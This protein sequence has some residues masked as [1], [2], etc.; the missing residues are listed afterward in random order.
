MNAALYPWLFLLSAL[1]P[2]LAAYPAPPPAPQ[3]AYWSDH[4][5]FTDSCPY[6]CN[7]GYYRNGTACSLFPT[8]TTTTTAAATTRIT[9][10][11]ATPTPATPAISAQQAGTTTLPPPIGTTT[12]AP[13]AGTT[14]PA[15]QAGTTTLPP[16]IGTTPTPGVYL[17]FQISYDLVTAPSA[18]EITAL[19][20]KIAISLSISS[21][22][23]SIKV[24]PAARRRLLSG[25]FVLTVTITLDSE[26]DARDVAAQTATPA[27][28]ASL[29]TDSAVLV[30]YVANSAAVQVVGQAPAATTA[31][32]APAPA[33]SGGGGVTQ[34]QPAT[35]TASAAA[36][37][38]PQSSIGIIVAA[39]AV[40][41]VVIAAVATG[42]ALYLRKPAQATQAANE[43]PVIPIR[44]D[45]TPT[46]ATGFVQNP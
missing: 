40:P 26:E 44:I 42:V 31:S 41:V 17:T 24:S 10:A 39:V 3:N 20:M 13:Q 12:L 7:P 18:D 28:Q 36:A 34:D 30:T 38:S 1:H 16:L 37:D 15:P 32:Q 25:G 9:T 21:A 8:T 27:F 46:A 22:R 23:V 5:G 29:S 43:K 35:T 45:R 4:G 2:S 14:T 33:P 19:R 6:L 11:Q